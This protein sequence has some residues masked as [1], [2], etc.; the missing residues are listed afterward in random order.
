MTT[1]IAR[2]NIEGLADDNMASHKHIVN[3]REF[4]GFIDGDRAQEL[5]ETIRGN[6]EAN[7]RFINELRELTPFDEVPKA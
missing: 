2:Q 3:L 6:L 4:Q 5:Q 1:A 7:G